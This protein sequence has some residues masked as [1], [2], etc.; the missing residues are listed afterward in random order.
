[1][2]IGWDV[3][4][5]PEVLR[6]FDFAFLGHIH[7]AQKIANNAMYVGSPDYHLFEDAGQQKAFVLAEFPTMDADY[8]HPPTLTRIDSKA[9]PMHAFN[10]VWENGEFSIRR[11]APMAGAMVQ[12]TVHAHGTAPASGDLVELR[13]K[14]EQA[15]ASFVKIDVVTEAVERQRV[16]VRAE[17]SPEAA[18]EAWIAAQEDVP[19]EPTLTVGKK[20]IASAMSDAT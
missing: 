12:V 5:R 8:R 19:M 20:L 14:F 15:G 10:S 9:R 6:R 18:L 17:D 13:R 7:R 4:I 16:P 1:M 2:R 11:V 3:T